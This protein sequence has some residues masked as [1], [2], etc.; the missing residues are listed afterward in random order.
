MLHVNYKSWDEDPQYL[1]DLGLNS[2]HK[3]TRERFLAL[4][5][6]TL[7]KNAAEISK[8][9]GRHH[10]TVISWIHKYNNEGAENLFYQRSGSRLPL[11]LSNLP[12]DCQKE[13]TKVLTMRNKPRKHK[14]LSLRQDGH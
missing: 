14:K 12:R 5:D 8:E 11:F 13:S 1:R 7:G 4:Y 10:Q 9:T 3:R 2:P 6:I